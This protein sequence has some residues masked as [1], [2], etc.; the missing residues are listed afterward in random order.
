M[1]YTVIWYMS[2]SCRWDRGEYVNWSWDIG[3]HEPRGYVHIGT[4]VRGEITVL[5]YRCPDVPDVGYDL[6]RSRAGL[7]LENIRQGWTE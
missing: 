2:E 4:F 3:A 5:Q 7:A 6:W 1:T